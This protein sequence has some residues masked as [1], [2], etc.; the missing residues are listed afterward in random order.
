[1]FARLVVY[2]PEGEG[3]RFF[4]LEASADVV[5]R[6]A[7]WRRLNPQ[8]TAAYDRARYAA[9]SESRK[10]QARAYYAANREA[11]RARRAAR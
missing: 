2:T 4:K 11:I 8:R 10:A 3:T 1:M 9:N 5:A 7:R 6:V